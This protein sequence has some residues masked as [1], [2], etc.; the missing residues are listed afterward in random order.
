MN[1]AQFRNQFPG[2]Q[3]NLLCT[4]KYGQI[5]EVISWPYPEDDRSVW[6]KAR[7]PF[8]AT[9]IVSYRLDGDNPDLF[10]LKAT[11]TR[12]NTS[13][14]PLVNYSGAINCPTC[15]RGYFQ[16]ENQIWQSDRPLKLTRI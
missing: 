1:I 9:T 12:D 16:D 10:A 5:L 13:F 8:D 14:L 2:F 3:P 4:N 11:C 15:G 6:I 7:I